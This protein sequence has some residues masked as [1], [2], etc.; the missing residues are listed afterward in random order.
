MQ[1]KDDLEEWYLIGDPWGYE[2]SSDDIHRKKVI[3]DALS[4]Y[5]PFKRALDIGCGE[6]F[7]T[8]DLPAKQIEGIEISDNAA[9]RLPKNV[10]RVTNP[11]GEYDLI[12]CTGMLYD[13]YDHH[14]FLSWMK[15]HIKQGGF[16]LTCNIKE[17]ELNTL[18]SD[19]QIHEVEFPYRTYTQKLRLYKWA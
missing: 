3:L 5:A 6:G 1:T 9:S 13:Q 8:T 17:W 10:K 7:I 11:S 4:H 18:P 19:N 15:S 2:T 12:V 16:I 14:S